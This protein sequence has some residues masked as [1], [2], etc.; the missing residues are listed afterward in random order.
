M[1]NDILSLSLCIL[2]LHSVVPSSSSSIQIILYT[3]AT[4]TFCAESNSERPILITALSQHARAHLKLRIKGRER[5]N[6][7]SKCHLLFF[8]ST[9][10]SSTS[11]AKSLDMQNAL[12][13]AIQ[14]QN[15][16]LWQATFRSVMSRCET[17]A[18]H[19][20]VS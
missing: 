1:H 20:L 18:S 6:A 5:K 14:L 9:S 12:V 4:V 2:R 11:I 10:Q 8:S 7:Q 17:E 3:K 16:S 13:H 15:S 19:H